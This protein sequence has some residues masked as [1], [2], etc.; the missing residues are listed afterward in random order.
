MK[1]LS[2]KLPVRFTIYKTTIKTE[3][4]ILLSIGAT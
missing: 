3:N 2:P 1:I 4:V